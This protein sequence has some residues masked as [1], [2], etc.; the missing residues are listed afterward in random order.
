MSYKQQTSVDWIAHKLSSLNWDYLVGGIDNK[1]FN[2]RYDEILTKAK[3]MDKQQKIDA[4]NQGEFNQGC[5]GS[6][7]DYIKETYEL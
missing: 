4:Y 3:E 7:E 5:N 6:P 2:I 1:T